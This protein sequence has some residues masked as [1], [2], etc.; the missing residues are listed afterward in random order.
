[1]TFT[2]AIDRMTAADP[3]SFAIQTYTYI[4]REQYGS[5][6]VD[7]TQP[8]IR[9]LKIAEDGMSLDMI[10]DGLQLGH[11][12]ELQALGLRSTAG[13]PLLHPQAYYTLNRLVP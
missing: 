11:V 3:A 4:Y 2:Q 7:H 5:P 13:E 6:E 10:L 12:H 1:L 9:S 8:S